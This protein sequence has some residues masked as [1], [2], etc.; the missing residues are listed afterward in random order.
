MRR[1]RGLGHGLRRAAAAG[2]IPR[3]AMAR[4]QY[5]A[6]PRR[7]PREVLLY[8]LRY[9]LLDSFG[10]LMPQRGQRGLGGAGA[11]APRGRLGNYGPPP[12]VPG[13]D[14]NSTLLP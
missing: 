9:A 1:S 10:Q 14:P 4:R 8:R 5:P 2:P 12:P 11:V 6:A 13:C 7:Y 3:P